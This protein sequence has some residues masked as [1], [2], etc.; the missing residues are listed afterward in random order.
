MNQQVKHVVALAADLQPG[1]DPVQLSQLEELRLLEGS[2]EVTFILSFRS[3]VVQTV[4]NP[5]LQQ[6][7]VADSDLHWIAL[8][9][10]LL[11]P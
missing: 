1:L 4:E 2:E 5:A 3:L 7:L 8:W 10:V 6:L 9:T 11:E